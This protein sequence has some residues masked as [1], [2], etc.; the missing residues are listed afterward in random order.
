MGKIVGFCCKDLPGYEVYGITDNFEGE[1][2][3]EM[4]ISLKNRDRL[5]IPSLQILHK[6]YKDKDIKKFLSHMYERG[7]IIELIKENV[8]LNPNFDKRCHEND[9]EAVCCFWQAL[10]MYNL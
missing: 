1:D 2:F 4:L 9:V 10:Q 3:F 5:V 8:T 7:V 6:Y